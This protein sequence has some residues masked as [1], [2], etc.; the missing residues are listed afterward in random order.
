MGEVDVGVNELVDPLDADPQALLLVKPGGNLPGAQVESDQ[1][2]DQPPVFIGDPSA[3]S[4]L[5]PLSGKP[6]SL[7]GPVALLATVASDLPLI[8]DLC[9]PVSLAISL[10]GCFEPSSATLTGPA[11]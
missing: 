5:T 1:L 10:S 4:G 2:L 8:V 6:V 3:D 9:L 11:R 7:G